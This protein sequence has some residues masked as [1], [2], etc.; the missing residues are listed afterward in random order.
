MYLEHSHYYSKKVLGDFSCFKLRKDFLTLNQT[1]LFDHTIKS[2]L[3]NGS[4]IWGILNGSNNKLMIGISADFQFS[5]YIF[6]NNELLHFQV[7]WKKKIFC[8][9]YISTLLKV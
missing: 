8:S 7:L 6:F 2:I 9:H 1:F 5:N 4:E 3:L